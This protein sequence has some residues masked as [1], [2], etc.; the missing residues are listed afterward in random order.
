MILEETFPIAERLN[1]VNKL[2]LAVKV[3]YLKPI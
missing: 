2:L 1:F 3:R